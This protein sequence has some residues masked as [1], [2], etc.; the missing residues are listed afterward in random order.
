MNLYEKAL[1]KIKA[2][3]KCKLNFC[4]PPIINIPN[5]SGPTGPTEPIICESKKKII[6]H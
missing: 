5:E 4:S 2:D 3:E 1:K 6:K